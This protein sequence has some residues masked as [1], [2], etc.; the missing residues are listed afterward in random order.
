M[1]EDTSMRKRKLVIANRGEIA[2]RIIR[3]AKARGYETIALVTWEERK[4]SVTREADRVLEI[5]SFL[6]IPEVV[7]AAQSV[8][9]DLLHPGYGFLSEQPEL[10]EALEAAHITFIGPTPQSMRMLSSKISAKE[11]ALKLSVPTLPLLRA[12]SDSSIE[13]IKEMIRRGTLALPLLIKAAGGGGGRGM[14]VVD[15]VE[16]LS[17]QIALAS[18][19]ARRSCNDPTV[20]IEPYLDRPRHIEVQILG[21]GNGDIIT[22]GE[23]ECSLQRRHQK[24]IEEA[25][26]TFIAEELKAKLAHDAITIAASA[27]YK[28]AGTVEFLVD[29]QQRHYFLEVNTRLQVE[30]PVTEEIF[31]CDL[32]GC[33]IDIAEGRWH[34]VKKRYHQSG[35]PRG[36]SI[37][38]RIL[39]EDPTRNFAPTPG[40]LRFYKVPKHVRIESLSDTATTISPH[41]DSLIAKLIVHG[42]TRQESV[43]HL[44]EALR[45]VVIH[46]S[47]TN[48]PFL[49]KIVNHPDFLLGRF[50]T[51]WIEH[52]KELLTAQDTHQLR[53]AL[54]SSPT[55]RRA[56]EEL[57]I[58]K[59]CNH[60]E[61]TVLGYE[62]QH[63][64]I[65]YSIAYHGTTAWC[66]I[67]DD[68]DI[69]VTTEDA[70][71]TLPGSHTEKRTAHSSDDIITI[72]A[73]MSGVVLDVQAVVGSQ[74]TRG[75][76]LFVVESMKMQSSAVAPHDATVVSVTVATG[77]QVTTKTPYVTLK[78]RN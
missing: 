26:A 32:V 34:E 27:H 44:R 39:A 62:E 38:V 18:D 56:L 60:P 76:T 64:V 8:Q 48:L 15:A 6:S 1:A 54:E 30:H 51:N 53:T 45:S 73:P 43:M 11:L 66:T 14:R 21:D 74:V 28:N 20:F 17:E 72:E 33:Q 31:N 35:A 5:S 47:T 46:G 52:Q 9:A 69:M 37:E 36:S 10:A 13:D 41:F 12:D 63:N 50:S 2:R 77:N 71:W 4:S 70:V 24:V 22:L 61:L 49:R 23:R 75:D 3:T 67:I 78:A 42:A 7:S 29:S 57:F 40:T 25:P 68:G 19:E 59:Q 16:K 65:S 58:T 55:L